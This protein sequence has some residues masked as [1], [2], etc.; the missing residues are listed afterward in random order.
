MQFR[1]LLLVAVVGAVAASK[2][3]GVH[4]LTDASFAEKTGDGKARTRRALP[5]IAADRRRGHGGRQRRQRRRA[6]TS[7]LWCAGSTSPGST[8]PGV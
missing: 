8:S 5:P 7:W 1:F 3:H 6:V 4:H 2:G